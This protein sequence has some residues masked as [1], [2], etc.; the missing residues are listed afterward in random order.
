MFFSSYFL[1]LAEIALNK[2]NMGKEK[3][4]KEIIIRRS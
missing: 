4:E 2:Q 3:R 1:P